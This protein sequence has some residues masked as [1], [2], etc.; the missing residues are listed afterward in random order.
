MVKI[1]TSKKVLGCVLIVGGLMSIAILIGWF[2]GLADA[3]GMLGV[4][5]SIMSVTV[6]FYKWKARAENIAKEQSRGLKLKDAISIAKAA[7][8]VDEEQNNY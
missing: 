7:D 6:G 3:P 8:S 1:E 4:V 5:V 2:V